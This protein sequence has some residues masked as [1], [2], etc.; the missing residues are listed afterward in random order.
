MTAR[1]PS[2]LP[3]N[4]PESRLRKSLHHALE[5]VG[6]CSL[7][8]AQPLIRLL[9]AFPQIL[10][11]R[12]F[13]L[14]GICYVAFLVC[15]LPAGILILLEL[16]PL[17]FRLDRT[18]HVF[19]L[20]ILLFLFFLFGLLS[21]KQLS[22][23]YLGDLVALCGAI[24]V[25]ILCV[26]LYARFAIVRTFLQFLAPSVIVVAVLF[27]L[28]PSIRKIYSPPPKPVFSPVS[29]RTNVVVVIFDEFSGNSLRDAA[30]NVDSVRYPHFAELMSCFTW[31]RNASSVAD[32]TA[33]AVPAMLAGYYPQM[34]KHPDISDYPENLFTMLEPSYHL[35]TLE[36]VTHLSPVKHQEEIE[37]IG[38]ALDLVAVYLQL[39]VPDGYASLFPSIGGKWSNFWGNP[40][41]Q[42]EDSAEQLFHNFLASIKTGDTA[43]LYFAH[44]QLP[45]SPWYLFPSG[46]TYD[47]EGVGPMGIAAV[48]TDH[49]WGKDYWPMVSG[50]QRYLLELGYL[51]KLIGELTEQ[52]KSRGLF[53]SS[54]IILTADHGVGFNLGE[55]RRAIDEVNRADILSVPLFIKLPNQQAGSIDDRNV[56]TIDILPT[57]ADVLGVRTNWKVEGAS[58]LD[59]KLPARATKKILKSK[60]DG[61]F[62][63]SSPDLVTSSEILRIETQRGMYGL[64]YDQLLAVGPAPDLIGKSIRMIAPEQNGDYVLR[65]NYPERYQSGNLHGMVPALISGRL[66]CSQNKPFSIAVAVNG[67]VRA[68]TQT[69]RPYAAPY[70]FGMIRDPATGNPGVMHFVAMVPEDSFQ[71]EHNDIQVL[72]L[73]DQKPAKVY[74]AVKSGSVN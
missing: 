50:L 9:Q 15:L 67:V 17:V 55:S 13:E 72:V 21:M 47:Y 19:H 36:S 60:S 58:L 2:S 63:T 1:K 27:F 43:T 62:L 44:V 22:I 34:E 33:W 37:Y 7:L 53:D 40:A 20:T 6:L 28:T 68:T 66:Y 24:T 57:I 31:Y 42:K 49:G 30:G 41:V 26:F 35:K 14:A 46:K 5:I 11:A 54:L 4:H 73:S 39:V 18:H 32:E 61:R 29:S 56:E 3:E 59:S 25:A 10:I 38:T 71:P 70:G 52:L 23:N 69:F 48:S 74:L 51:D 16:L 45:H 65:L 8:I 12:H 64:S